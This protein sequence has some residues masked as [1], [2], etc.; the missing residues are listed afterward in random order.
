[1]CP[2][3][4]IVLCPPALPPQVELE[5]LEMVGLVEQHDHELNEMYGRL[6]A[7]AQYAGMLTD[8]RQE[9]D[10]GPPA[11]PDEQLVVPYHRRS[12][13]HARRPFL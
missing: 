5:K 7:E 2:S 9:L 12:L 13:A 6:D 11:R 8:V 10:Q 3:L 4:L 1:M